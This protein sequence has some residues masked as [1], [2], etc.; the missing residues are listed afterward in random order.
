M[1]AVLDA[2]RAGAVTHAEASRV[3]GLSLGMVS[4]AVD[5]LVRLGLLERTVVTLGCPSAGC[6]SCALACTASDQRRE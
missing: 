1:S 3:T 5:H 6:G 2:Y 4:A